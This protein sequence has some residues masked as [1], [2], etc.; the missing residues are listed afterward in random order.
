M[1]HFSDDNTWE[2]EENLDL[3]ELI[4]AFEE[5]RKLSSAQDIVEE[6]KIEKRKNICEDNRP[7]GFARGLKPDKIVGATDAT[8]ELMFL[9][10]WK[11]CSEADLVPARQANANCPEIVINYYESKKP[12]CTLNKEPSDDCI[13]IDISD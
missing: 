4:A 11:D 7:R 9:M 5:S 13:E 2:P 3:P 8:G 12:W 1:Y 10:M 6:D